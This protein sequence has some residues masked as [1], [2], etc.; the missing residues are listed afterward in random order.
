MS[1]VNGGFGRGLVQSFQGS[2]G[3]WRRES[4][5]KLAEE[6]EG[7]FFGK[8]GEAKFLFLLVRMCGIGLEFHNN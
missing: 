4:Y 8:W 1:N 3:M 2:E 7:I 5:M 6:K